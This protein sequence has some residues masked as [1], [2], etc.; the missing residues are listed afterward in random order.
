MDF[1]NFHFRRSFTGGK[2]E[3]FLSTDHISPLCHASYFSVRFDERSIRGIPWGMQSRQQADQTGIK[4]HLLRTIPW[5]AFAPT[6]KTIGRDAS[7]GKND[8]GVQIREQYVH[9][10]LRDHKLNACEH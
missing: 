5:C 3:R 1:C 8:S 10:L 4:S 7:V 6:A 9:A 2:N